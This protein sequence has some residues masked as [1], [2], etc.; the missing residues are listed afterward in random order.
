MADDAKETPKKTLKKKG[1]P[2]LSPK[3][4]EV[5][6]PVRP[7]KKKTKK[8]PV[9]EN[10]PPDNNSTLQITGDQEKP[11][12]RRR[13]KRS[14]SQAKGEENVETQPAE[15]APRKKKKKPKA[16]PAAEDENQNTNQTQEKDAQGSKTSLLSKE[17]GTPRKKGVKKKKKVKKHVEEDEYGDSPWAED[18]KTLA[19]DIVSGDVH[20]K[21][22]PDDEE[23]EE[24]EA[25]QKP[26]ESKKKA[27]LTFLTA[28]VLRSQPLDKIFI[29]TSSRFKGQS[30]STLAR[31]RQEET[32]RAPD[33]TPV[34][35]PRATTI[36]F[37]IGSHKIFKVISLFLH[38]LTAGLLLW[39]M[40]IVFVLSSSS[41][42]D[43]DFLEHYYRVSM[44]LQASLYFLLAL[45]TVSACDR[46]DIGNPTRR[47]ILR[48]L[49]LQNGAVA[50]L[51]SL[52]ALVINLVLIRYDD[53]M[54]LYK[55]IPD[56]FEN[57]S[58]KSDDIRA[59][60]SLNA[61]RSVLVILCW[62]VLS[63][64]PTCDRLGKNLR[65]GETGL[66]LPFEMDKVSA[67]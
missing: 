10:T 24:K 57:S 14:P 16:Q 25:T 13:R 28:P 40:V 8:K 67:A 21:D 6:T 51:F 17:G 48:A 39:Q 41:F 62:L 50:I 4:D 18:L 43:D 66:E 55:E 56:I 33:I 15:A 35:I 26:D 54:Y 1:L 65:S 3:S 64:V 36:D 30:K 53:K 59:F 61:A 58:E 12:P 34:E 63:I 52:A 19:E 31:Q 60:R 47:F 2:P 9:D 11:T 23:E 44:P 32:A 5:E 20:E 29:E 49:T 27:P 22:E 42:S 38:G 45:G 46:F 7:V 37:A